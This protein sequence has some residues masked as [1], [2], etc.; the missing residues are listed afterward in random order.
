MSFE[1][2]PWSSTRPMFERQFKDQ[3]NLVTSFLDLSQVYGSNRHR[4][5]ALREFKDGR[6][7]SVVSSQ[8]PDMSLIYRMEIRKSSCLS[9]SQERAMVTVQVFMKISR[10]EI[11]QMSFSWGET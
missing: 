7:K 6:L 11:T 1:R 9:I 8:F 4:A 10:E 3:F 2:T 5:M